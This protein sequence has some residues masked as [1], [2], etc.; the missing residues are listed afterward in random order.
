MNAQNPDSI[1]ALAKGIAVRAG[2]LSLVSVV[3]G[4]W[5]FGV[6]A[7]AASGAVKIAAT[8]LVLTAG[9][10]VATYE[11]KRLQQRLHRA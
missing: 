2:I 9:A 11:V 5:V 10:G 6:A 8:L 3:A 4:A 7:R 1:G